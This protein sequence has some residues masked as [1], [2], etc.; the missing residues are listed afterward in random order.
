MAEWT[1]EQA[2]NRFSEL[3]RRALAHEVQIVTRGGRED[4][5]VVVI[6]RADFEQL[7]DAAPL[8]T[9]LQRSPLAAAIGSG[10]LDWP[11]DEDFFPR[12]K[13]TGRNVELGDAVPQRPRRSKKK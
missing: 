9:F 10:E 7:T 11:E 8:L 12:P 6:S 3:V 13:D 1:L 2:K 5:S 4:E